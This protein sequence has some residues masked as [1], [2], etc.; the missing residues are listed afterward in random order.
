M[1]CAIFPAKAANPQ[2]WDGFFLINF[3]CL[4]RLR[5]GLG[6]DWCL[7]RKIVMFR[8]RRGEIGVNGK[9]AAVFAR[10]FDGHLPLLREE[11]GF[12]PNSPPAIRSANTRRSWRPR[13]WRSRTAVR[14]VRL[15]GQAMQSAVPVGQG[16]MTA[17]LNLDAAQVRE[18]CAWTSGQGG[19]VVE[20][21]NLN[22]PGQIVI[23]G[24]KAALDWLGDNYKA[25]TFPNFPRAKLI[26]LKVSAPFHCQMMQPAAER[27]K[28]VLGEM[29][30]H[31][32]KF[33]I[34]QN[35]TARPRPRPT[36]FAT[37][38][39]RKSARRCAGSSACRR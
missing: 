30:F 3:L 1:W 20:P 16:G 26:P 13:V 19:G 38:W 8:R 17:V 18:L 14:A 22:A 36:S 10:R 9:Y 32:A 2:E 11:F 12:A 5:R 39:S 23:S 7:R 4:A 37:T 15:R 25:E 21:A 34:V 31:A 6:R 28:S 27:M 24:A 35:V 33:P 29:T